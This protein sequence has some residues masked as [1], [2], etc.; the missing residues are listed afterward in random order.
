MYVRHLLVA[1]AAATLGGSGLAA[2]SAAALS[3]PPV[4]ADLLTVSPGRL[5]SVVAG[6]LG[7]TGLV[8]G[9]LVLARPAERRPGAGVALAAG[10]LG[11]ALGGLVVATSD[12]GIGTG[13]GRAGGYVALVVGVIA[14]TLG[15]LALVRARRAR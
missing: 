9:G 6:L 10:L 12:S 1:T 15:G 4:A 5:G 11:T 8:L 13:N 3:S 14:V 7:L 2:P